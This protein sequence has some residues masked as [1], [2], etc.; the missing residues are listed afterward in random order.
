MRLRFVIILLALSS[1]RLSA[2]PL[3]SDCIGPVNGKRF[4]IY[5]HGFETP[6]RW[7][8]E[9]E[10]NR[11]VLERLATTHSLRIALPQGVPCPNGKL[12]W[13]ARSPAEI[14]ETFRRFLDAARTCRSSPGPYALLGFS[15]GG[16]F[17]FKLYK[18]HKDPLLERIFAS[19]SAGFWGDDDKT[20][21]L[22]D[23]QLM[24]GARD[25]TLPEA[26]GLQNKLK[27]VI[28]TFR[29]H[30]FD[31]GHALHYETLEKLIPSK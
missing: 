16:Y 9:E 27:K 25:I 20:N 5:L 30:V 24:I 4:L 13:P 3:K 6:G 17:A 18:Q 23:F 29:L 19:G 21:P 14:Q 26:K 12:C 10:G 2:V 22:S 11:R 15:N 31:G 28:P 1:I 7:S 8:R